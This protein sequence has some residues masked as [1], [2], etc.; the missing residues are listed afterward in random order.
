MLLPFVHYKS[1][2]V[3]GSG[4]D[5]RSKARDDM[6]LSLMDVSS[7]PAR[8]GIEQEYTLLE[9]DV[10]WPIGWPIGGYPGPQ[11]EFQVGPCVGISAGDQLWVARYILEVAACTYPP[12]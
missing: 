9:K 7:S 8:F 6:K 12:L 3:G 10:K 4:V 11:W 5:I 1:N 2:R